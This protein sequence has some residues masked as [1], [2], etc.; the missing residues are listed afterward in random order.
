MG[1]QLIVHQ[2]DSRELVLF[3]HGDEFILFFVI[4]WTGTEYLV[5]VRLQRADGRSKVKIE[6]GQKRKRDATTNPPKKH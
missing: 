3:I 1:L 5:L 2:F 6:C 4:V